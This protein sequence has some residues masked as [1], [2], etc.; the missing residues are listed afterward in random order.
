MTDPAPDADADIWAVVTDRLEAFAAAWDAGGTLP[1]IAK[2][3]PPDSPAVRR[4]T[5]A[6]LIKYDLDRRLE[7]GVARPIEDYLRDFPELV[8]DGGPPCDLLYED[9]H[10]RRQA[11][12]PADPAD[13]FK[14][15]PGQAADLERLLGDDAP[16]HSTSVRAL[17]A[18]PDVNV[19]DRLDDFDL[20]AMLGEGKLAKVYLARQ[21]S[22]Q[23]LVALKVSA[24]RG[25]EAETLAQLDHPNI[26]RVYDQRHLPDRGV[27]LVYMPYLAGG[28]LLN[29]VERVRA[30]LPPER[31]GK[32]LLEA[33][34]AALDRRGELPPAASAAR[35]NWAAMS[36]PQAVG[37]LGA[38]LAR[39][40]DYAHRRGVLHRDIKPAN[41]LLTA[42]GE[43]LLADFNIGSCSKIEGAGPAAFFGGSL[44]YMA[45]EHLEAFNPAHPRKADSLDGRADVYSLAVTLWELLTGARPFGREALSGPWVQMITW[46]ASHR[47]L[48]PAPEARD[49]KPHADDVPGLR[50]VLLRC[51]DADPDRRPATAGAMAAELEL[52]LRP[53]TRALVR[54]APGGWRAI[55]KRF[56]V[57]TLLGAGLAP[58]SL[59]SLFNI[60]YNREEIIQHWGQAAREEFE[61]LI[62]AVNF[63]LYPFGLAAVVFVIRRATRPLRAANAAERADPAVLALRRR[64]CLRL[65]SWAAGV[66]VG[67]W[68]IAGAIWPTLLRLTAGPP[69]QGAGVYVHFALS[70]VICGLI[71]AAYPYFIVT[72]LAV[73]ALYP[74]MLGPDGPSA[75]DGPHLRR[76]ER[77]LARYRAAAAAVPF[78]A[79]ALL[80]SRDASNTTALAILGLTGFAG[81]PVAYF[82]EGKTR[83]DLAAL[84]DVPG[85]G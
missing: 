84:A 73:R 35:Q 12:Q 70:L 79:V 61:W 2:F 28:T 25:A 71:A 75:A 36:W 80:A 4:L 63:V 11:G 19:G 50:E 76:V 13:Y 44:A 42:E 41:V 66:C 69:P 64:Q 47:R 29:V 56:P 53:A 82:L 68:V 33:V 48:G 32:T 65:G 17:R 77:E 7:K 9:F 58:S 39:A 43:P 16:T 24:R 21:R 81:I 60:S 55:V 23:R 8:A 38:K 72:F 67:G 62:M 54:P 15:F 59:A 78:L 5:L 30:L 10:L 46:L 74:A 3:L 34:D 26:V 31:T 22:M 49:A 45:P 57:L 83:A 18:P 85:E 1:D 6:E 27:L 52:C 37:A 40:M 20:L 51:L 14:R